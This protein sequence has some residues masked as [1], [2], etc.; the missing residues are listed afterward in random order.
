MIQWVPAR[1]LERVP[2]QLITEDLAAS[3]GTT[4]ELAYKLAPV[5][6]AIQQQAD[7]GFLPAP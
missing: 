6:C 7:R 5:D 2:D 1:K 3:A 4:K